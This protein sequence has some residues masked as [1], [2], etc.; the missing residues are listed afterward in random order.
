MFTNSNAG[1]A[2]R[3]QPGE[4]YR[5][6]TR[7]NERLSFPDFPQAEMISSRLDKIYLQAKLL[8]IDNVK[9]FLQEALDPPSIE[10]IEHAE[11]FLVDID[12]LVSK[13]GDLT[14]LGRILAQ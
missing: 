1:R 8:K 2:G 3:T 7:C 10:G 13:D 12:A 6:F 11:T 9:L 4:C 14:A 5:L